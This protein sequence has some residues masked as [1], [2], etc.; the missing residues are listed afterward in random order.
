MNDLRVRHIGLEDPAARPGGLNRYLSDLVAAERSAGI[1]AEGIVLGASGATSSPW[2]AWAG[3]KD[4]PIWS[5]IRSMHAAASRSPLPDVVDSH[6]ALYSLG[7]LVPVLGRLCRRPLVVHFQGPWADESATE[8]GGGLNARAKRWIEGRVY[9]RADRVVV[10][11][12]AFE[13]LVVERYGVDPALVRRIPPGVDARH[14]V[15]DDQVAAR[16]ELGVDDTGFVVVAVRR[17]RNRMGLETAIEAIHR[18]S[19]PGARLVIVGEGPERS[20]LEALVDELGAPVTFA[21][22]VDDDA[23]VRWYQAADVSVV[24]TVALEGFGLVVLESLACGTPVIASDIEG[25][26]DALEGLPDAVLVP[27]GDVAS[28]AQAFERAGGASRVGL[29]EPS[30]CRAHAEAHG[31]AAIARRHQELYEEVLGRSR[32]LTVFIGHTAL[33]SGGELALARLVPSLSEHHRV[34]VI[35][36]E[37]GPLVGRLQAEGIEVEILPMDESTRSM[38]RDGVGR[39]SAQVRRAASSLGYA[40]RLARRLRA[41]APDQVHTNSLKAALYGGLAARLAKVP[42]V[43]WHVRDRIAV[44]Y[45]PE[46]AVRLV[47]IMARR[48][49]DAV[50]ANSSSTLET[51]GGLTVPTL[52]LPSPL[53]PSITPRDGQRTP[54]GLRIAV[55]GRL[56]PWKGQ[57]LFLEAFAEAFAGGDV[58][59]RIIG[60]PL[61]GEDAYGSEL[62]DRIVELGLGDQVA[63]V[64][65]TEDVASELREADVLVHC[66]RIAEPFGQVVI[67]GMG[68]GC[69]VVAA[70]SGGPAESITDGVDG[71]LYA[72]G[73]ARA[74]AQ[75]LRRVA[76]DAGL[77]DRLGRAGVATAERFRPGLLAAELEE[78]YATVGRRR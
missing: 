75:V 69:C 23:L 72:T 29:T 35:L 21:G 67:E 52:V 32:P 73:S 39:G 13:R 12:R 77:R 71:L 36:A 68:A 33:L 16:R 41:L 51:L 10:L 42:C 58:T 63:L 20:R 61:F 18:C 4:A 2:L 45:L 34:L 1:E 7:A 53:D 27:P 65:F 11:S 74:L 19:V 76:S 55:V 25:L 30:D 31:W 70:D 78:F 64:G 9:R 37:D 15:P 46:R 60:A 8:G 3:D 22:R 38:G 66:S 28:L 47:R 62:A 49:P 59:A 50:V 48:V 5:R 26:R 56:A 6:F 40:W 17:L 24:P 43:V 57:D 44:D 54:G 14:F